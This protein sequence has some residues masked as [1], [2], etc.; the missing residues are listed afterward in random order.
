[1]A[2]VIA[3]EGLG[4]RYSRSAAW[5]F[6]G[7]SFEVHAGETV[8]IVGRSGSG[9]ST[10]LRVL[11][12]LRQPTEGG[13]TVPPTPQLP[14][15]FMFQDARLL[16][17]RDAATNVA[18]GCERQ[19]LSA[20]ERKN[21][22]DRALAA[23]GLLELAERYPHQLS[24]GQQQRI[25]LARAL[26]S[27]APLLLLDEP[28]ASLDPATH[29]EMLELLRTIAQHEKR[30]VILV[31]HQLSDALE[32]GGRVIDLEDTTRISAQLLLAFS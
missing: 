18:L 29:R 5:L 15:A 11:G 6:R 31:T 14:A 26:V 28:F 30:G 17:W 32:L 19:K 1:M 9:K 8:T 12:G 20:V 13:V 7:L 24:G 3:A 25:A 2:Q 22:I 23:V 10:L 16:P 21:R 27:E 4:F